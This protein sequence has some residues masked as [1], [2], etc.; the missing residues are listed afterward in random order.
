[1]SS[2]MPPG[3]RLPGAHMPPGVRLPGARVPGS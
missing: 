1:M 2:Y 3:V